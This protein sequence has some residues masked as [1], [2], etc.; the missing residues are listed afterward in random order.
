MTEPIDYVTH[1]EER[2]PEKSRLDKAMRFFGVYTQSIQG[3]EEKILELLDAFQNWHRP[4]MRFS[5][6]LD[7]VGNFL[8]KQPRPA[9][10]DD[11]NYRLLLI[12]RTLVR[13][14]DGTEPP[15]N[16]V[17][18]YL[19]SINGGVGKYFVSSG[20]LEHWTID[21]F[22]VELSDQWLTLYARLI[23]DA[24]GAVDSFTLNLNNN[25]VG[26]YDDETQV[27]DVALYG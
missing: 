22:N 27:Y 9:T 11:E 10:F 24:I 5:F 23:F 21:L 20:P 12:A 4:G 1:G 7:I 13:V 17:I 25:A 18:E 16:A 14:S 26:V 6:V 3:N 15:V 2:W 8:L 19:A